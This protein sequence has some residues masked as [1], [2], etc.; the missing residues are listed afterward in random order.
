MLDAK[1]EENKRVRL[2][3]E[4]L[5]QEANRPAPHVVRDIAPHP[6]TKPP[7]RINHPKA[8]TPS[9][10]SAPA[11]SDIRPSE[12]KTTAP[13]R[14][15]SSP[16]RRSPSMPGQAELPGFGTE[17]TQPIMHEATINLAPGF[18]KPP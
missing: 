9:K 3:T 1:A 8:D 14:G 7:E 13:Q 11:P 5:N 17:V 18:R 15:A 2:I 4:I 16:P 10:A 12:Q 6:E